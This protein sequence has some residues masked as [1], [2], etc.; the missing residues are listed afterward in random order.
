MVARLVVDVCGNAA[1]G[2]EREHVSTIDV[3]RRLGT[4]SLPGSASRASPSRLLQGGNALPV[5]WRR[6][7]ATRQPVQLGVGRRQ[8]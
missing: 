2:T 3:R 1:S 8:L 5:S 7:F 4:A 6:A